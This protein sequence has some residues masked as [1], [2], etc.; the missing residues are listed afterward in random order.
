MKKTIRAIA[1]LIALV[2]VISLG[3]V[4]CKKETTSGSSVVEGTEE[5]SGESSSGSS[6]DSLDDFSND[7]SAFDKIEESIVE[8][9]GVKKV[10]YSP[11]YA[12]T[13]QGHISGIKGA[14][15]GRTNDVL[16]YNNPDRGY[17]TTMPLVMFDKHPDPS[18]PSKSSSTCDLISKDEDG[19]VYLNK[20]SKCNGKHD[21][22]NCY[23]NLDIETNTKVIE[24]MF[25]NVYNPT[26]KTDYQSKLILLQGRFSD[27]GKRDKLPDYVFDCLQIF[28][29]CCRQ[30]GMKVLFRTSY[31]IVQY[32]WTVSAAYK[33]MHEEVGAS[34]QTMISHIKQLAPLLIKNGDVMHKMSSGF[35]GSGGE[36]AYNYQ[37]PVVNYDNVIKTIVEEICVPLGIYYTARMPE[38][39]IN[40]LKNDPN[41]KY[42]Y[43][44]GLNNDAMYG[45]NENYGWQSGCW[46]YNHNFSTT[47]NDGKCFESDNGGKHVKNDWWNYAAQI[48]AY[49]PQSGE[50]FHIGSTTNRGINPSGIDI[51]KQLAHHRFTSMSQWNSY[52]E[53]G[54]TKDGK[55]EAPDSV[56]QRWIEKEVLTPKQLD[57]LGI[58]YD[59]AW[60]SDGN[61]N[62]VKRN[63][64]EFIRDHLGYRISLDS[65]ELTKKK[66]SASIKL[67]LKNYGFAAAFNM[68]SG[69]AVLDEN[70]KVVSEVSAGTPEKWYSHSAENWESTEILKH[71]VSANLKLPT[72]SGKYYIAFYLKNS[73]GESARVAND[74]PFRNGYNILTMEEIK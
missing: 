34:E 65:A 30:R 16:L 4:G 23:G 64:Y 17:R 63:P 28:F 15:A 44:I 70:F 27:C 66:D 69:F 18:N 73:A 72:K 31:H 55:L 11:L 10:T 21:I 5:S 8:A 61:G 68:K 42:Q 12:G 14:V 52:L 48:A 54:S 38:Y 25:Q 36:M 57:D 24:Y 22:R 62:T 43:L 7:S 58:I 47:R 46:Q 53:A 2:L 50:M 60:F 29:D 45:E 74:I 40:L 37:Y 49:T 26:K 20:Q 1:L 33:K 71:T 41:Y 39:R 6:G 13:S 67:I 9:N 59:P 19:R 35:I 3:S 56:M 51:I 32:N